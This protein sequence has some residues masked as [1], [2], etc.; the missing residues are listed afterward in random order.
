MD[1]LDTRPIN[2]IQ[3]NTEID[4][5]PLNNLSKL[6]TFLPIINDWVSIVFFNLHPQ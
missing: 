5:V 2:T 3:N 6:Y 1:N 4:R